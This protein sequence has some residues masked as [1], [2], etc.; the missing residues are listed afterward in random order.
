MTPKAITSGATSEFVHPI[1][2][3]YLTLRECAR[4]QGFSDGF[5]FH[6]SQAEQALLIGNAV[7]PKLA[8]MVAEA[9]IADLRTAPQATRPVGRLLSFVPTHSTGMSPA[10]AKIT[11]EVKT[12]FS[13]G[14]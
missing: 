13:P 6:G 12:R 7:P 2:P 5:T 1:E 10:L 14:G 4:V 8:R 9:L 11:A 3:R